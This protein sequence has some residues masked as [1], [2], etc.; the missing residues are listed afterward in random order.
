MRLPSS[1]RLSMNPVLQIENR[2]YN[3]SMNPNGTMKSNEVTR[4]AGAPAFLAGLPALAVLLAL[5]AFLAPA[6]RADKLILY[7]GRIVDGCRVEERGQH[8][9][10]VFEHG[11]LKLI[12]AQI[13]EILYD[14]NETYAP[15]NDYEREQLEK[16]FVLFEGTWMS[17]ERRVSTLAKRRKEREERVEK[18]RSRL[19]WDNAW[20]RETRHFTLVTN[21][22]E[23]LLETYCDIFEQ[24]YSI[25]IKKWK[26]T[27]KSR[28]EYGKPTIYIYR[29]REQYV[30]SGAPPSSAGLFN[31]ITG[32]LKLYHD[33]ADPRYTLDVLF[34]EG[35]HLM[36]QLTRPDF[37]FP[38]W[39]NEGLAEYFGSSGLDEDGR[40]VTG[41][42]QEGRLAAL[43]NAIDTGKYVPL[44]EMM[45]TPQGK[46]GSLH[47][48][49]TWCFVHYLLEH[50]KYDSKFK[51]FYQGLVTGMGID[52]VR[53]GRGGGRNLSTITLPETLDF[54]KKKMSITGFEELEQEYL[55]YVLYG[56]PDVGMR[57]YVVQ[58]RIHMRNGEYAEA[59]DAID[60]ALDLGSTDP[61][62]RLYQGRIYSYDERYEESV[63]AYQRAIEMAPLN[64]HFH[65]ELGQVLRES[66]DKTMMEEGI[67]EYYLATEI[68]PEVS[69]F[70]TRLE[71]ALSGKDLA[72]I[73]QRKL[74]HRKRG[75]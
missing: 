37:I 23:D 67:R 32:L 22:S 26:V 33:D 58:A 12:P 45:L 6:A 8:L 21:S 24:F 57:G 62:C 71:K 66:E 68:A 10:A 20:K 5:V 41:M 30:A 3:N 7:D 60:T 46:F 61:K 25:F 52:G 14:S 17:R 31:I 63:V 19:D 70:R 9:Y 75:K 48:A 15:R 47:Y 11:A 16:G 65:A 38:I 55:D 34:H 54:F 51:S 29:D 43:R 73:R 39:V 1:L 40:V 4:L 64:P 44:Q 36:V 35:T 56:L 2:D 72:E 50:D 74:T 13:K 18:A 53:L 27:G 49:E 59:L 42:I 69:A 28:A